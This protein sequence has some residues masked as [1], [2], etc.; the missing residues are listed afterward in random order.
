MNKIK[1]LIEKLNIKKTGKIVV[2]ISLFVWILYRVIALIS[3]SQYVVFNATRNATEKGI[4]VNVLN[5]EK[6][7]HIIYEP[8]TVKNNK[9]Y[10][11]ASRVHLFEPGQ[12]IEHGKV[13][14]VS[15]NIDLDSGM[16]IITTKG[17]SDGLQYAEYITGV[18][19]IV[20]PVSTI[21]NNV[22]FIANGDVAVSKPVQIIRQD[23]ENAVVQGLNFGDKVI[24]SRVSDGDKIQIK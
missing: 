20:I 7:N 10:V 4:P 3:E 15:Q 14:F 2:I 18:N 19:D 9:A 17:V 24:L 5:I 8:L 13:V 1:C 16:H 6:A 22:V 11:S 12:N 23:S 21:S